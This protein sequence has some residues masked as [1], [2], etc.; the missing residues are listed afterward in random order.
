MQIALKHGII[1]GSIPKQAS[2]VMRKRVQQFHHRLI[3]VAIGWGEQE[4]QDNPAQTDDTVD[5]AAKVLQSFAATDPIVGDA[6]KITG[7]LRL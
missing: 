4:A 7:L 2:Q 6:L 1:V 3:V 5:F